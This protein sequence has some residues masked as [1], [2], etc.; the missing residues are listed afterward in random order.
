M[1]GSVPEAFLGVWKRTLLRTD[2]HEDTTS[3]VYWLQTPTWHADIRIPSD[4]PAFPHARSFADLT[5][6]DLFALARQ[7]GF[8]GITT[9]D[10]DVCRWHRWVD[11]QPPSGFEDVGR[12]VF[13]SPDRMLEHGVTQEYLEIWE[14]VPGSTGPWSASEDTNANSTCWLLRSGDRA[15]RVRARQRALPPADSL[16][17]FGETLPDPEF[18]RCLDFEISY[19]VLEPGGSW[20]IRHSTLP[21]LEGQVLT[22]EP[23]PG[24]DA[25]EDESPPQAHWRPLGAIVPARDPDA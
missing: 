18:A 1:T 5:R 6:T 21:W 23:L 14:R 25:P 7:Q 9:V 19:C 16:V 8:A 12:I 10:G 15:M 24:G 13:E 22:R 11:F 17:R 4:R 3:I 2:T 20:R